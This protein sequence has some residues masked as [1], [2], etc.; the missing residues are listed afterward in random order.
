MGLDAT[1]R[2]L[3]R[4]P[5]TLIKPWSCYKHS[6]CSF[7]K[8]TMKMNKIWITSALLLLSLGSCK[9]DE[10]PTP[11]P[12][13]QT[14]R[15]FMNKITYTNLGEV[16]AGNIAKDRGMNAAVV[17]Y[18]NMMVTDHSSAHSE[19]ASIA[20]NNNAT[21]PGETDQEHK[22]MA[23][24]LM[25]LSG[26]TFDSVYIHKMIEGHDKAIAILQDEISNGQNST[27][28]NYAANKLPAVQHHRHMADSIANALFP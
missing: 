6:I 9:K 4:V 27:V 28:K 2:L 21:L 8:K 17:N 10:E 20:Q 5:N 19:L 18:G 1:A 14:D 22:N 12:L 26:N 25:T 16:D 7:Q 11:D 3:H 23:A 24:M 15:N 13:S